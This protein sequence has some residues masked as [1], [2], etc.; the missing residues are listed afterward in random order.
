LLEDARRKGEQVEELSSGLDGDW[1]LRTNARHGT[2]TPVS[3]NLSRPFLNDN[4]NASVQYARRNTSRQGM[5]SNVELFAQLA[6]QGGL[7]HRAIRDTVFHVR[8]GLDGLRRRAA[9]RRP[10]A[11]TVCLAQCPCR[12]RS[13]PGARGGERRPPCGS[14][15]EWLVRRD[16]EQ[17]GR[18]VEGCSSGVEPAIDRR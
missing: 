10:L 4:D 17:R 3:I 1:F 15:H 6:K 7:N 9:Q 5:V 18:L 14:R 13:A 16:T 12:A 8:A 11:L 2:Y